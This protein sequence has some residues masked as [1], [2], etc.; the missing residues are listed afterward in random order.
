MS[1]LAIVRLVCAVVVLASTAVG[2]FV[3]GRAVATIVN[4]MRVGRPVPRERLHPAGRRL[5]RMLTAK[6]G[7][8]SCR[9]RV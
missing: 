4:R 6:I 7:R 5:M 1:P 9:E 8:A 3:F 2:V